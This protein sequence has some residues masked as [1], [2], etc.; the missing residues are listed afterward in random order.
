M[1]EDWRLTYTVKFDDSLA[2]IAQLYGTFI[3]DLAAGNCLTNPDVITI[4]QVLHVPGDAPPFQ[5]AI[6]CV[7]WELLIPVNGTITISGDGQLTFNWRGP[8]APRNVLRIY[9]ANAQGVPQTAENAP[10]I[11]IMIEQ[12][13]N[14]TIDLS[15][16]P[17]AGTYA[18]RIFPLTW[19]YQPTGCEASPTSQFTKAAAPPPTATPNLGGV[20]P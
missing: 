9:R 6:E 18:W 5:T 13:Q 8:L 17:E 7:P 12:R 2:R 3:S 10:L 4:G 16:I 20:G 1:R 14:E 15:R 19:E 11:E